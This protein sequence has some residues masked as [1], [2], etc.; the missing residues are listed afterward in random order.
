MIRGILNLP[1]KAQK[2]TLI[3]DEERILHKC[4]VIAKSEYNELLEDNK[5]RDGQCPICKN[6]E[7]IVNKISFIQ[8]TASIVNN[9]KFGFGSITTKLSTDSIEVNHCGVCG[10]EWTKGKI[11]YIT[12]TDILRVALNYLAQIIHNPEEKDS[13]WKLDAIQVFNESSAKAIHN[14]R[15]KNEEYLHDETNSKL[16][17]RCLRKYY[18]SIYDSINNKNNLQK[19]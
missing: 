8:G 6:K 5:I 10:N 12:A 19:L 14:L 17:L 16:S 11:K 9:F 4:N 7:R 3:L 18:P 1:S 15:T 13:D 2:N